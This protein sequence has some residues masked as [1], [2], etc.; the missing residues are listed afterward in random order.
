MIEIF[1]EKIISKYKDVLVELEESLKKS[2]QEFSKFSKGI[3]KKISSMEI[4][5][6]PNEPIQQNQQISN[7]NKTEHI[8]A[9]NSAL[10]YMKWIFGTIAFIG[11]AT[12]LYLLV[13]N[14]NYL[15]K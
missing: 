15:K 12:G 13:K 8:I 6:E 10:K 4:K 1:E 11:S 5:Q 3:F 9:K 7:I 2:S 14:R